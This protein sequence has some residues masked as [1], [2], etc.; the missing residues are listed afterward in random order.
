[1]SDDVAIVVAR[2]TEKPLTE[3]GGIIARQTARALSRIGI[4]TWLISINYSKDIVSRGVEVSEENTRNEIALKIRFLSRDDVLNNPQ[5]AVLSNIVELSATPMMLVRLIKNFK[6]KYKDVYIFIVNANK[7]VG[8]ILAYLSKYFS[9]RVTKVYVLTQREELYRKTLRIIKP[10]IILATSRELQLLSL[11]VAIPSVKN[12]FFAYPPVLDEPKS[13]LK[14]HE[15]KEPILMYLGRVNE[16]RFPLT[17]LKN[18]IMKLKENENELKFII[19]IPP[20]KHSIFWL[21]KARNIVKEF[22]LT[23]RVIFIPRI[24]LKHE[25]NA[26][27]R[28]AAVFI[29]PS[30]ATAAV[31][32]PLSVLEAMSYGQYLITAGSTSTKELVIQTRGF[33]SKDF[34]DLSN[35]ENYVYIA[36]Q[37]RDFLL[38]WSRDNLNMT[39]FMGIV[40]S[41]MSIH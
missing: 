11:K 35:L 1:M 15:D 24:L 22:N 10:D 21:L 26:L 16:K 6:E 8:N 34:S 38:S 36:N 17:F 30:I 33:I 32:P 31:E 37:T 9:S 25:K 7:I 23:D 39:R 28:K 4:P 40:K 2:H 27:L 19:A 20:E 14:I 41:V 18:I 5:I 13:R 29:Y 12:I 3:G